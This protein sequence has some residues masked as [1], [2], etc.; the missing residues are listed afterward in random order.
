M[1]LNKL[2]GKLRKYNLRNYRQFMFSVI[3]AVG[4]V[5]SFLAVLCSAYI[6]SRLPLGG[7]SRKQIYLIF[8]ISAIGALVFAIYSASLFFRYKS[9]EVG[10][11][12][13]LGALKKKLAMAIFSD[14]LLI[15]SICSLIGLLVGQVSA[16]IIGRLFERLITDGVGDH[17]SLSFSGFLSGLGFCLL[18]SIAIFI[19]TIRFMSK[20][21]VMDVINEHRKSEPIKKVVTKKYLTSGVILVIVG[22]LFGL[23]VPYVITRVTQRMLGAIPTVFYLLILVGLYRILV[24]SVAFHQKGRNPQNYYRNLISYGLLKFQ[25]ASVVK[26]MLGVTLL[27]MASLYAF[28]YVPMTYMGNMEIIEKFPMDIAY[29]YPQSAEEI[30]QAEVVALAEE[31]QVTIENYQEV[32]FIMLLGSGVNRDEVDRQGKLIEAPTDRYAYMEFISTSQLKNIT[33]KEVVIEPGTYK[34]IATKENKENL[35]NRYGDLSRVENQVAK[36]IEP[37]A[38]AGRIV[39]PELVHGSGFFTESRYV[40]N[41]QDYQRLSTDLPA[42]KKVTQVLIKVADLDETYDFTKAFFQHFVNRASKEM[43]VISYYDSYQAQEAKENGSPYGYGDELTIDPL[44][45]KVELDWKYAPT[46]KIIEKKNQIFISAIN[47]LV[48]LYAGIICAVAMAVIM[49]TRSLT[50]GL[51]N[52]Q[53]FDDIGKLGGNNQFVTEIVRGQIKKLF[54][55]PTILGSG[56]ILFYTAIT[57]W[58][59]DGVLRPLEIKVLVFDVL[60]TVVLLLLVYLVYRFCFKQVKKLLGLT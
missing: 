43:M 50:V 37:L 27:I 18:I 13:A 15:L 8:A 24:Y 25:G 47:F 17:F 33:K 60:V 19:L 5:S 7:D 3:F 52:K 39:V 22:I 1:T 31:H 45:T 56:L 21:N 29:H 41:D 16:F 11:F 36:I 9:R 30:T 59:N 23:I 6:Q 49:Y 4:L 10:I 48:F 58:Q 35:Y 51:N 28:F 2:F 32:E 57:Y 42:D 54:V 38:Y 34:M 46:L 20:T 53:V 55:L 14:V 12:M 26:N 40:I 44:N